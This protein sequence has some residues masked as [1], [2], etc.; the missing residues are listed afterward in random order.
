M[1][2]TIQDNTVTCRCDCGT[3]F[4]CHPEIDLN[5]KNLFVQTMLSVYNK[6]KCDACSEKQKK[7]LAEERKQR[8]KAELA[9]TLL[10]REETA[11]FPKNFRGLEKPFI[12]QSAVFFYENR[13]NNVLVS[14]KTGTG[15]TSSALYVLGLMMK[16]NYIRVKYW[17]RQTMLAA[18]VKAKT[19]ND[20]CEEWFFDRLAG[21]DY[22]VIDELVGKKGDA[23]LSDS[24]Q[25]LFF[26]LI[27]GVYSGERKAKLWIMGN[28]YKGAINNLVSDPDPYKRRIRECFAPAL[29]KLNADGADVTVT[30]SVPID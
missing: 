21:Y 14:G 29:F 8:W 23:A 3:V 20:D 24:G 13:Y 26:N 18:Y 15:K 5:K 2:Q 27:D 25:E 1:I 4:Q 12:R 7:Q 22:I 11:G 10:E 6:A 28:F 19:S 17:T 9:E 16:E 30:K